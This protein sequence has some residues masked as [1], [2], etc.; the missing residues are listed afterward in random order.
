MGCFFG[1]EAE[2]A[3]RVGKE[4]LGE[5]AK[6]TKSG[7][8]S[9]FGVGCGETTFFFSLRTS[10]AL[11]LSGFW[12]EKNMHFLSFFLSH[13]LAFGF[14]CGSLSDLFGGFLRGP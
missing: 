10:H 3:S 13:W 5:G 12:H 8:G 1:G 7:R 6:D 9:G 2:R 4:L 11:L 14:F